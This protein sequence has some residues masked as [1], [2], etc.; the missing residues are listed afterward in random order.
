MR[1]TLT[2]TFEQMNRISAASAK[3]LHKTLVAMAW[4][5][6]REQLEPHSPMRVRDIQCA[7]LKA[8]IESRLADPKLSVE[9]IAHACGMSPRSVHRAF[10]LDASGSVSRYMWMRRI[11]RCAAALQ[12][13]TE[14]H[15]SITE[16]CYSWGFNSTS[17]F[18][19]SFK[20]QFGVSPRDYREIQ[21]R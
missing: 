8:Y 13:G 20:D 14:A 5:A 17:H 11:N 6:V 3:R 19:R 21:I 16:I 7:Q 1:A 18:S 4:D 2:E 12:D 15:R 9:S 10:A